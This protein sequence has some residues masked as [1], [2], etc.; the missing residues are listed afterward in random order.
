MGTPSA[1]CFSHEVEIVEVEAVDILPV[2]RVMADHRHDR[3]G[4][5]QQDETGAR[6]EHV[7]NFIAASEWH[8]FKEYEGV[9]RPKNQQRQERRQPV[10]AE[11]S[12]DARVSRL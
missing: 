3:R 2:L 7:E 5:E 11:H 6:S 10:A 1:P 4:V 9:G 8:D 12:I